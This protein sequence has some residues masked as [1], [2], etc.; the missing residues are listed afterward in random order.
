MKNIKTLDFET[1]SVAVKFGGKVESVKVASHQ[2]WIAYLK[3]VSTA[4]EVDEITA[5]GKEFLTQLGLSEETFSQL[6]MK[7][8]KALVDEV[9]GNGKG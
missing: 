1:E 2:E 8:I 7:Q 5:A 4:K 3:R 6:S 9:G